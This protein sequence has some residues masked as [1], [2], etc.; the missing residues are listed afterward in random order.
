MRILAAILA[1]AQV[2]TAGAA[3]TEIIGPK[4]AAVAA[5]LVAALQ[6]GEAR[7]NRTDR[8]EAGLVK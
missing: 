1:G 2:A 8:P 6:V 4:W 7:Y 5:L 3:L